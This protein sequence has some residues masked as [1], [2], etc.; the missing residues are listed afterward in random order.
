M[1]TEVLKTDILIVGAGPSGLILAIELARRGISFHFIE[2]RQEPL[3]ASR[4]KGIQPRTL[5][6]FE[7]LG[8]LPAV[9]EA[10]SPYPWRRIL[11][12]REV[13]SEQPFALQSER[14]E[15][16]PY[17]NM[18]MV[19]QWRTEAALRAHLLK[20]GGQIHEGHKL[21]A[22]SQNGDGVTATVETASRSY[23]VRA[24][25]MIGTDGG[26]ST[27]RNT[28][29]IQMPGKTLDGP[30]LFFG[31]L[32]IDCLERDAW[33][34]W[35]NENAAFS[36]CPLPHTN[37]FQLIAALMPD[38]NPSLDIE[39][40]SGLIKRRTGR[41]DIVVRAAPWLSISTPNLRLAERY[42]IDRIFLVGDAAH[43]HPPSGG[44]GLNTSIGDAYNLGWK[45]ASVVKGAPDALLDTYEEERR[46]IAAGMLELVGTLAGQVVEKQSRGRSTQ[47]LDLNYRAS[48]MSSEIG[49]GG[50]VMAGDRAP[51]VEYAGEK[52]QT[53]LF[54]AFQGPHFTVILYGNAP[55]PTRL[56]G[57]NVD[58]VRLSKA[59]APNFAEIYGVDGDAI[60]L[61]RPD[62]Y[63]AMIDRTGS[64][65]S[66]A[67]WF[68]A[69]CR[70]RAGMPQRSDGYRHVDC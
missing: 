52:G 60:I 20:L 23:D 49:E 7:D 21:L 29:N 63:I 34:V 3:I 67:K 56:D 2:Q 57:W 40:V 14:T 37:L 45:L 50:T 54:E 30:Q 38:D 35:R 5:E 58:V 16:I 22:F 8:V 12:V 55:Q 31:D 42:R 46:P 10:S 1:I 53:R 69:S 70:A 28:L 64:K 19:P 59:S 24:C 9:L 47:Q 11:N 18:L 25:Y 15:D 61:I 44:Q 33:A 17:P 43:V 39:F 62:N 51:D 48:S 6:I 4:G 41:D 65:T 66:V 32:E 27:I 68:E 26:R 13:V 36:L